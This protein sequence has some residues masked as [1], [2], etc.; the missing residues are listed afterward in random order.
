MEKGW[1]VRERGACG[2]GQIAVTINLNTCCCFLV[3]TKVVAVQFIRN[4]LR[5]FWF[6]CMRGE[7]S[8]AGHKRLMVA[9]NAF[10]LNLQ[11]WVMLQVAAEQAGGSKMKLQLPWQRQRQWQRRHGSCTWVGANLINTNCKRSRAEGDRGG[12]E[13]GSCYANE[14][15]ALFI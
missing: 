3:V 1:V 15:F 5:F 14:T 9:C 6:F 2:C 7:P 4:T 12:G 11:H 13:G 10:L 8:R